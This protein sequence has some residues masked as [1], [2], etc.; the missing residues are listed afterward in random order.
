MEYYWHYLLGYFRVHLD[1]EA[2]RWSF[3]LKEPKH[4]IAGWVEVLS[5]FDLEVEN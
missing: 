3:S 1:Y 4:R 2:L 5:E